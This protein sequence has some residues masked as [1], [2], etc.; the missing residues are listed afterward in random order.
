MAMKVVRQA[1]LE[2][3]GGSTPDLL[4]PPPPFPG[5]GDSSR[6]RAMEGVR[7]RAGPRYPNRNGSK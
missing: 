7:V 1:R 5:S 4:S 2:L 3:S 6:K